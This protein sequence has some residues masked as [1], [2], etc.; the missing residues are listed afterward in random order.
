MRVKL[1]AMAVAALIAIGFLA[2]GARP[3]KSS[4][5]TPKENCLCAAW[6]EELDEYTKAKRRRFFPRKT[7]SPPREEG[8]HPERSR[9][10]RKANRSAESKDPCTIRNVGIAKTEFSPVLWNFGW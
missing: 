6:C 1:T 9:T 10:I 5:P 2:G 3:A 4:S 8:C 7:C